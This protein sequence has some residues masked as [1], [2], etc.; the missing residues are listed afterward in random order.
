MLENGR[1]VELERLLVQT[2]NAQN[3]AGPP[4]VRQRERDI[5]NFFIEPDMVR[6]PDMRRRAQDVQNKNRELQSLPEERRI[7]LKR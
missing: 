1:D 7:R 4:V 6:D 2:I 5:V 3:L